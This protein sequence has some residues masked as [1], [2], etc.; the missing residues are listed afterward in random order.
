MFILFNFKN[1]NLN[2]ISIKV[3]DYCKT[4]KNTCQQICNKIVGG[5][6][7]SC[8]SGFILQPDGISCITDPS[9]PISCTPLNCQ[10]ICTKDNSNNPVCKCKNG[11]TLNSDQQTCSGKN[12]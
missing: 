3:I 8:Y 2:F 5:V 12:N 9:T 6:T 7:C 1:R 10:Q 11:F 4:S